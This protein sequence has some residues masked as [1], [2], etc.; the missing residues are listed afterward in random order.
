MIDYYISRFELNASHSKSDDKAQAH[1]HTFHLAVYIGKPVI[2][3]SGDVN[4]DIVKA[5]RKIQEYIGKYS[6]L[7]LNEINDIKEYGTDIEGLGKFFYESIGELM[8]QTGYTVYQLNISDNLIHE[9]QVSDSINLPVLNSEDSSIN[10][11][12]ILTQKEF[13][14]RRN[15]RDTHV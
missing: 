12:V 5:E 15:R 1:N 6:G 11:D 10:Y 3:G 14:T 9:Y 13:I 2:E 4:L 7:Y 8:E